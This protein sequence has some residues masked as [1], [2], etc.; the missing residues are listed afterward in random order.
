MR[1]FDLA[2]NAYNEF[3]ARMERYWC[4]QYLIQKKITEPIATVWRENL[5]RLEGI[6]YITKVHSLPELAPGT[7][8]QLEVKRID[9]LLMELDCRFK[10]VLAAEP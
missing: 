5:V 6:P 8:V 10:T 9:P 4:L 3:Q 2:Y 1:E 7:R